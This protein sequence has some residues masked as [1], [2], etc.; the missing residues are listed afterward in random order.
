MGSKDHQR[1][2]RKLKKES[3]AIGIKCYNSF[4]FFFKTFWPEMSGETYIDAKHIE[5]LCDVLQSHVMPIIRQEECMKTIVINVPPGSSKSTIATIA[6]PAWVWLRRP[7]ISTANISYSGALSSQHAWKARDIVGGPKWKALFTDL[8]TVK[9]GKPIEV[10]KMNKNEMLNNFKGNRYN[11]SVDGTILGMHADIFVKDDLVSASQAVSDTER[12][13]ANDWNDNTTISRRKNPSC[14]LDIYIS[15]RLHEDDICGHV[16]NKNL[17]ITHICLPSELT[18]VTKVQP[19]EAIALY[20]DGILDPKRRPK[21]VLNVIKEEMGSSSYTGQFLQAPFNLEEMDITPSMFRKIHEKELDPQMVF[22]LWIDGA[23]TEKTENDPTGIDLLCRWKNDIIW[24]RSYDVWK[25]LPDLLK[26]I[27]E[28]EAG[29]EFDKVES[30]IFIEP[31]ASGYPLADLLESDTDYNV[32]RIGEHSKQE[33][34]I[35]QA[36]KKAR[37]EIIKPKAESGRIVVVIDKWN[38]NSITQICGFPKA[39]HDEHV[40]NLGYAI[41]HYYLNENTFIKQSFIDLLSKQ[42]MDSINVSITAEIDQYRIMPSFREIESG[43]IQMFDYPY[44]THNHRYL[45]VCNLRSDSEKGQKTSILVY[46]RFINNI[47]ILFE[48]STIEAKEAGIKAIEISALY[49]AKLIHVVVRKSGIAHNEE[50]DLSNIA[51]QEARK[52]RYDKIYSRLTMNTITKKREREY[53]FEINE[54]TSREIF[55]NFK[56]MVESRQIKEIPQAIYD[57]ISY[58]ERKK[59]NGSIGPKEGYNINSVMAFATA[60]KVH[61]EMYDKVTI[62]LN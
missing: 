39:A 42:I 3:A 34:K 29:G 6:F 40:D 12:N 28:L 44:K 45:C 4:Y 7:Q 41:N 54:G 38:D 36:G 35:V 62:R 50:Y 61:E 33:S 52:V 15:Q 51:I 9:Y 11:T 1:E 24:K 2:I 43:D 22:D 53:G 23:F 57:E 31:K 59:E 10:I 46:D 56:N 27:Q 47:S 14:F 21:H 19:P 8:L 26:F 25:K 48:S 32:V 55:Y 58:I 49:D 37:H 30:R 17:D 13:H 16:L 60:L 5:Y 20:T 18:T